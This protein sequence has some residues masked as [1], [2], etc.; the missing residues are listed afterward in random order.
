MNH[1]MFY[2]MYW[3]REKLEKKHIN[4]ERCRAW[5]G[6]GKRGERRER[7]LGL[8]LLSANRSEGP[9]EVCSSCAV[10]SLKT[11]VMSEC[12]ASSELLSLCLPDKCQTSHLLCPVALHYGRKKKSEQILFR[13]YSLNS[14]DRIQP[15]KSSSVNTGGIFPSFPKHLP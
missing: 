2:L 7:K 12:E 4:N 13:L 5:E 15:Q 11:R 3:V 9:F 8:R 10:N 1:T 14:L 6:E